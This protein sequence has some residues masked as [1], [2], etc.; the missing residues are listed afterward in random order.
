MAKIKLNNISEQ[1]SVQNG[2]SQG[3]G[4]RILTLIHSGMQDVNTLATTFNTV[5]SAMVSRKTTETDN[6]VKLI[7][8][9]TEVQ[10]ENNRHDE[11]MAKIDQEWK[12]IS[13]NAADREKIRS[14]I[15]SQIERFQEKYD[16]YTAMEEEQFLGETVTSR[17]EN[18]H[19]T[20]VELIKEL[21]RVK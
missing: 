20:I 6:A 10:K 18:L 9:E 5:N 14:F 15:Q 17:L 19:K 13:D 16:M 8:A 2:A 12:K 3:K 7:K 4:D 1:K 11:A 21:S